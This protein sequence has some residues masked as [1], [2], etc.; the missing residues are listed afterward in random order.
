MIRG[1]GN[2]KKK[3]VDSR[4]KRA[5]SRVRVTKKK[6]NYLDKNNNAFSGIYLGRDKKIHL[7]EQSDFFNSEW[8]FDENIGPFD[9]HST[10][11]ERWNSQANKTSQANRK[12]ESFLSNRS[13]HFHL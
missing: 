13:E 2:A 5:V 12:F 11:L 6:N 4:V 7:K 3:N 1:R 10:S 8:E 9:D